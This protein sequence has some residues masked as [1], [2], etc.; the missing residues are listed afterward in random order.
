[1]ATMCIFW[2]RACRVTVPAQLAQKI[3]SLTA[4]EV[5]RLCPRGQDAIVGW[6]VLVE[7]LLH[8]Q[9]GAARQ[10]H[11]NC[12]LCQKNRGSRVIKNCTNSSLCC[13]RLDSKRYTP[14]FKYPVACCGDSLFCPHLPPETCHL[15]L[16]HYMSHPLLA[17]LGPRHS[18]RFA[19]I[20]FDAPFGGRRRFGAHA[21]IKSAIG[22]FG[23]FSGRR[24]RPLRIFTKRNCSCPKAN[25]PRAKSPVC[26]RDALAAAAR[27]IDLGSQ[28][29]FWARR[30]ARRAVPIAIPICPMRSRLWSARS[31]S[32]MVGRPRALSC[33]KVLEPELHTD[34]STLVPAKSL[35][36]ERSQA[37]GLGTPT[38]QTA[39][40]SPKRHFFFERSFL[41]GRKT[42][43]RAGQ[44][45][46]IR[47]RSGGAGGIGNF[48][49]SGKTIVETP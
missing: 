33:L 45:Q 3:K 28:S 1:M 21:Q 2:C 6:S 38:Y 30:K 29:A 8:L 11:D 37:I 9:C 4:R 42:R 26:R 14:S 22:V 47:R 12:G 10:C 5:L 32:R 40:V 31:L 39:Q 18:R 13:S 15:S 20:S 19:R 41:D 24:H 23:R 16:G 7:R 44:F 46:E 34:P 48:G 27:R 17:R 43:A 25:S 35:L 49:D 36:Q